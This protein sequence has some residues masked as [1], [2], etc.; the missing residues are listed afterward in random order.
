MTSLLSRIASFVGRR[1]RIATLVVLLGITA[2]IG[3]AVA[4]GGSFK[5]DFTVP[6]I[7]SQKAQDLLEQRFPAQSGTQATVVFS[8]KDDLDRS[9]VDTALA[10]IAKQ[11]HVVSV[12][13]PRVS[14]DG[15]VAYATVSYDQTATDLDAKARE[16]LEDATAKLP[17]AGVAV[18]MSGEPIDGAAT[19][20]FPVGEVIGLVIAMLLLVAVLR[21]LRAARNALGAAF[22]GIGLGFGALL[23]AAAA[24]DVPGLAPTLAGMLGLGAGI[25][26]ALLLTA[27]QQEELR[28]GR[29]PVEAAQRANAT[30]GH[31]ALTAAG[32]V[33]VSI[34]GLLVTGIPFV[35]RAGVAAGLVVLA[36]AIV[37][38][39]LLPARFARGGRKM[40]PRRER[41][42]SAPATTRATRAPW[43]TKRPVL[44]LVAAGAIIVALA[45]PAIG[46]EL[47]QPDDRNLTPDTTQRQAY[48]RLAAGFGAGVNGPLVVAVS[49]SDGANAESLAPLT[50][51]IAADREVADV[52]APT[53]NQAGDTAVITVTPK[54][55]PQD[56][57]TRAL[58]D[59]LRQN[60]IPAALDDTG[61]TA[62]VGGRTARYGDEADKIASR[63]PLF[64]AAVVGLSLLLLL[65]AFR[66]WRISLLSA[67]FNLLSIAAAYGVVALAFQTATGASLLGIEQQPVV[68]Y[69]PLFMFAILFGLSTDYNVFLLSRVREEWDRHTSHRAAIAAAS[70][71]TRKIITAAGAI[72]IAVFLGFATDPDPVIKMTGVGLAT[73]VLVDVT[74]VRQFLAPAALTL[75]GDRLWPRRR[76]RWAAA[77]TA[78][79]AA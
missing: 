40:L 18:A 21:S 17:D 24:T 3:G 19:G 55:G 49:L 69:V 61:A 48:D 10:T 63:I 71:G 20:G 41:A 62:Y 65:V 76:Q 78:P 75:L 36:C 42:E 12:D 11:P 15:R 22:A 56:E 26:Y 54:H 23:W 27:R 47:G 51:Q 16:R 6:G 30:A 58:V 8:A 14:D 79:D 53:L 25:D 64:A 73:A 2:V 28:A 33:L 60:V 66:S 57:N 52:T 31:S 5:D 13:D 72:M 1:P 43:A 68:P 4:V 29:S 77:S 67:V 46:L 44:A 7:E 35:G 32:I 50:K 45:A 37:C 74:L 9:A 70:A 59:R 38:V 34:S 39:V